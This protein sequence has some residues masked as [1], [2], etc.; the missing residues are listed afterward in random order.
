MMREP[1]S[2][3]PGILSSVRLKKGFLWR[4][5][6]WA[7][8]WL[9]IPIFLWWSFRNTSLQEVWETL[10]RL[11]LSAVL[12]LAALNAAILI[13]LTAR[14][15]WILRAQGYKR[16][17]PALVG[18]RLAAFG[19]TYLTPGPQM[20]GEP[21]QAYL[22]HSKQS[23]P[24]AMAVASVTLDRLLELLANFSFLVVGVTTMLVSGILGGQTRM[25]LIAFPLVLLALPVVY[26][27]ALGH[28]RRP[29]AWVVERTAR[30]FSESSRIQ[31]IQRLARSAEDEVAAFCQERPGKVTLALL[32]S[33]LIWLMIIL[34][35]YLALRYLGVPL[36]LPQAIIA[37]TAARLAFLL[38]I[39]AGLGTLEA[40]QVWAMGIMGFNPVAG[41][42]ISLLIRARDAALAAF[43]LWWGGALSR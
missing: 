31:K 15:W 41:L 4:K 19:V 38:P 17:F 23:V 24:R 11:D 25:E 18:Y 10:R 39:P 29:L 27:L 40:G 5:W 14:W 37:L 36:S 43:G 12:I 1:T 33:L 28:G 34:E 8:F 35:F 3:A 22:L 6:W 32:L 16:S 2:A 13:L 30:L 42:S 26:M 20:G 9:A 7:L 21:F